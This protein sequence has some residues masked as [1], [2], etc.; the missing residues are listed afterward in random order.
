MASGFSSKYLGK[1]IDNEIS[2]VKNEFRDIIKR[3]ENNIDDISKELNDVSSKIPTKVSELENDKGYMLSTDLVG[4]TTVE[5]GE[6]F[7][8]YENNQ[9]L[10]VNSHAEGSGTI[11]ASE[12]QHVQGKFNKKDAS[13]TYAHIIGNGTDN[14]NR[15]NAHTVDWKGN[16][17]YAG[18]VEVSAIILRS[19]TEGSA[20]KFRLTID[21]NGT[22]S[23]VEI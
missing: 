23:S 22:L 8:D 19:S 2:Y 3:H 5:G 10:T 14:D 4:Q 16:A 9:A 17:F 6:I 20:K 12:N 13:N 18:E 11:A 15:S 7:N 21:D 1:E